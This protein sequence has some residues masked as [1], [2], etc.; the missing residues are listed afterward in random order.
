M[1]LL[2]LLQL[3]NRGRKKASKSEKSQETSDGGRRDGE[4]QDG[5][6]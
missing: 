6:Q 5:E 1:R 2:P 3:A 4:E